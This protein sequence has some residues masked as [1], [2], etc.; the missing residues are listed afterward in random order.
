MI[1]DASFSTNFPTQEST[2]RKIQL[3]TWPI[4]NWIVTSILLQSAEPEKQIQVTSRQVLTL[5]VTHTATV[6]LT[7]E[8]GTNIMEVKHSLI[9]EDIYRYVKL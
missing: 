9:R 2:E 3:N 4:G 5:L 6:T 8:V 1:A 7:F